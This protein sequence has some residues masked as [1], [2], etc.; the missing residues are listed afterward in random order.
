MNWDFGIGVGEVVDC[1]FAIWGWDLGVG[2]IV[3]C[4]LPVCECVIR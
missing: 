2:E 4:R 3:D 1:R